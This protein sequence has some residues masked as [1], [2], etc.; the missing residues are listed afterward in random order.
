MCS[1]SF[2]TY[3]ILWFMTLTNYR[4]TMHIGIRFF[5][6]EYLPHNN[7]KRVDINLKHRNWWNVN[8]ISLWPNKNQI[9]LVK[10]C[11]KKQRK[12][13][14]HVENSLYLFPDF[15]WSVYNITFSD[16]ML[17]LPLKSS[18]A[19]Q[20]RVPRTPPE[21]NVCSNRQSKRVCMHCMSSNSVTIRRKLILTCLKE[22][23]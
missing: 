17:L 20:G 11:L 12:Q 1:K 6:S 13:R 21:T 8:K 7:P 9:K 15:L 18:G 16:T 23:L 3:K 14:N 19:I 22:N 4:S 10:K 2:T 5:A